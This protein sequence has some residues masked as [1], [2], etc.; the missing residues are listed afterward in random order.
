MLAYVSRTFNEA[1]QNYSVTEK[2]CL[3]VAQGISK[4]KRYLEG[5]PLTVLTDQISVKWLQSFQSPTGRVAT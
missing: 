5:Y 2:E 3:A 4:M 1:E